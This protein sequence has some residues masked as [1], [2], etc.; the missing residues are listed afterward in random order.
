MTS[1]QPHAGIRRPPAL[2]R[3]QLLTAAA[4]GSGAVLVGWL[5]RRSF[6]GPDTKDVL[7]RQHLPTPA[8]KVL[9]FGHLQGK[10]LIVNFWATW[11][12]PCLREMPLLSAFYDEHKD[13]GL[14]IVGIAIDQTA[15]VQR[16]LQSTPVSYPIAVASDRGID[17]ARTLGNTAGVLPFSVVW[18]ANGK[19]LARHAG[20]LQAGQ[21]VAWQHLLTHA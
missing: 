13:D 1:P 17:L 8:G 4:A 11:C 19:I 9:D 12:A 21:L 16:F 10:P 3:R 15:A 7:W 18:A 14:Q 20:E 6:R 5:L 2:R